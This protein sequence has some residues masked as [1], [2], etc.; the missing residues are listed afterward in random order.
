MLKMCLVYPMNDQEK[1][2]LLLKELAYLPLAI[3]QA[4]AYVN[5]NKI[6]LQDYLSLLAKQKEEV[7]KP[8]SKGCENVL[9]TT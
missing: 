2:D 3:V 1:A 9:A 4:A 6:T 7:V 8:I 5:I